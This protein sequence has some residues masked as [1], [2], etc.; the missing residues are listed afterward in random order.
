MHNT[1]AN[2]KILKVKAV[3]PTKKMSKRNIRAIEREAIYSENINE[4]L[5]N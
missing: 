1:T 5:G 3:K 2:P 4:F